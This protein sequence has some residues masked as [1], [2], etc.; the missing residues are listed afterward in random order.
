MA[1]E[2]LEMNAYISEQTAHL[3][4]M[5][6]NPEYIVSLAKVLSSFYRELVSSG[7]PTEQALSMT[8]HHK[9]L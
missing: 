2:N 5:L 9:L 7:I 3:K 4:A 8:I 1:E 6:T